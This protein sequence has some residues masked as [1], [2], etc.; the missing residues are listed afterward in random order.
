MVLERTILALCHVRTKMIRFWFLCSFI[1]IPGELYHGTSIYKSSVYV[2]HTCVL[3]KAF[4]AQWLRKH[5]L[6]ISCFSSNILIYIPKNDETNRI[7]IKLQNLN[8]KNYFFLFWGSSMYNI[9][10]TFC[11]F[12]SPNKQFVNSVT[13]GII[14]QTHTYCITLCIIII[15]D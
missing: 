2:S 5:S 6:S 10:E 13:T 9:P 11:I 4:K 12:K 8:F 3:F 7:C 1:Y 15:S 14:Q